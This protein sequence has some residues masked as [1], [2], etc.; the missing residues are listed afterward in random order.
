MAGFAR[1]SF[2]AQ[3]GGTFTMTRQRNELK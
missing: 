3:A 1:N 2:F